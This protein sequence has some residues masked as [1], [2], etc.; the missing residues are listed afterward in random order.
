MLFQNPLGFKVKK[1][2][3]LWTRL[4]TDWQ[5]V[6]VNEM[7]QVGR[8]CYSPN[9]VQ[10]LNSGNR[11]PWKCPG[12]RLEWETL[13]DKTMA[14]RN[15]HFCLLSDIIS[16]HRT[17]DAQTTALSMGCSVP[18]TMNMVKLI[19]GFAISFPPTPTPVH[20]N[21]LLLTLFWLKALCKMQAPLPSISE[22]LLQFHSQE[23]QWDRPRFSVKRVMHKA[24]KN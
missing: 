1:T 6:T 15:S 18:F 3:V 23:E 8:W 16:L 7:L 10:S 2:P 22:T 24:M 11:L 21:R 19:T 17:H 13:P 9:W 20:K 12:D 14:K 4:N 5:S